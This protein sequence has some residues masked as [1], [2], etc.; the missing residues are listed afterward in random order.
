[1]KQSSNDGAKEE[2]KKEGVTCATSAK[3]PA[4]KK[5]GE[6]EMEGGGLR[7]RDS[8]TNPL[9]ASITPGTGR[10]ERTNQVRTSVR[11]KKKKKFSCY[12]GCT[13]N[14]VPP[15]LLL[16]KWNMFVNMSRSICGTYKD[17]R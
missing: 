15:H 13:L 2:K 10:C 5:P 3:E 14:L 17:R 11:N 12:S 9:P 16:G 6:T 7:E 8:A 1:M 4:I